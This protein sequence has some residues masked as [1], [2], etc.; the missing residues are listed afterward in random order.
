MR[1]AHPS[2]LP[3]KCGYCVGL[4]LT[5]N[6]NQMKHHILRKHNT[7]DYRIHEVNQIDGKLLKL[8]SVI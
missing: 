5:Q 3:F 6:R 4:F 1:S 7:L 8:F 2:Y